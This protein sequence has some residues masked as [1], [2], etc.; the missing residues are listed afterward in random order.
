VAGTPDERP[1]EPPDLA[2]IR[3]AF[4]IEES[5]LFGP[6]SRLERIVI[7]GPYEDAGRAL[8]R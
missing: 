2:V 8:V 6:V 7:H 3:S 5:R 1:L 4:D